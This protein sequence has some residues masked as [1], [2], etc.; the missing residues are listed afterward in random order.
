MII[1]IYLHSPSP[2]FKLIFCTF[3]ATTIICLDHDFAKIWPD[4]MDL[5]MYV[6]KGLLSIYGDYVI[7]W[8][9]LAG[10]QT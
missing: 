2:S 4:M 5:N 6:T 1:Y 8:L 7:V 10:Q 9:F 3:V